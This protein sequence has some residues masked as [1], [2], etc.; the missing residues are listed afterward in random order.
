MLTAKIEQ[1]TIPENRYRREFDRKKLDELKDSI[2]RNGLF[3]PITVEEKDGKL[4]LVAGERRLKVVAEIFESKQQLRVGST[5]YEP[6]TLPVVLYGELPELRRLEIEVEENVVRADFTWQERS[7]AFAKLHELRTRQ[8]PAQTVAATASEILG[9]PAVGEQRTVVADALIV[10][11]HLNDPAVAKAKSQSEA[12]KVIRKKTEAEHRAKLAVKFDTTKFAHTLLKGDAL[13]LLPTLA[14]NSFDVL[15]TDPPY[16]IGADNFGDQ[17]ATGHDYEDNKTY[18]N[19]IANVL[20]DES[21]RVCKPQA[22]AYVFCDIRRF[23]HLASLMVLAGWRVFP[24]PM[25][26]DKGNGMLPLPDLG[27]RRTYECILYAYKGDRKTLVVKNDV[28][29]VSGIKNLSHAA[30]KPVALYCDLLSRSANPGDSVLD[31][32]GGSGPILVAANRMRLRATYIEM[33]EDAFNIAST[34]VDVREF[35]DGAQADDGIEIAF[36]V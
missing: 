23:E 28:I 6:G 27:P 9:K 24:T 7:K 12:I 33:A 29:S 21:F 32:F 8:N 2:L 20:A 11:K 26:W 1:I 18:F 14:A 36:G 30:Q 4:S 25:I 13:E 19:K 5:T 15:I 34:R 16:G 17:S 22:H 3:N 35:D 10:A 31:C